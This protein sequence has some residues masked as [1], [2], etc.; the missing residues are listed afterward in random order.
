MLDYVTLVRE[1]HKLVH[2]STY[3]TI[4]PPRPKKKGI[5]YL[6]TGCGKKIPR[7]EFKTLG[8]RSKRRFYTCVKCAR[9]NLPKERS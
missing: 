3:A 9:W 8:D 6:H 1:K 7:G 2:F 5:W 4:E